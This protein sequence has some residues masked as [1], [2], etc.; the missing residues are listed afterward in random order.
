METVDLRDKWCGCTVMIWISHV[1]NQTINAL[2]EREDN[3]QFLSED[4]NVEVVMILDTDA[5]VQPWAVMVESFNTV[6]TDGAVPA[7]TGPNSLTIRTE[8]S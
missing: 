5:I 6:S 7:A 4:V 8:L 2:T 1:F 3:N